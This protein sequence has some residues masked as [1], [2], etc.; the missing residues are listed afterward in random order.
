[1]ASANETFHDELNISLVGDY[2]R[3][4]LE[5]MGINVMHEK[6]DIQAVVE[7][8]GL[9]YADSYDVT[10]NYIKETIEKHD[11]IQMVLVFT[12]ILYQDNVR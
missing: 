5:N 7:K 11:S 12:E 8:E 3:K 1:M 10:R 4:Q 6:R 9:T 2:L